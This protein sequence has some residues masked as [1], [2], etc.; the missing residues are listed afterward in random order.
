M[1]LFKKII[2]TDCPTAGSTAGSTT[3]RM[4]VGR[5]QCSFRRGGRRGGGVL[6]TEIFLKARTKKL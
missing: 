4:P 5:A 6:K 1:V 3:G 2:Y